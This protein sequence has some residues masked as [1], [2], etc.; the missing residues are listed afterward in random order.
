MV[1]DGFGFVALFNRFSMYIDIIS[2]SVSPSASI[3][4]TANE[5]ASF[6]NICQ[7]I[8][9]FGLFCPDGTNGVRVYVLGYQCIQKRQYCGNGQSCQH[10]GDFKRCNASKPRNTNATAKRKRDNPSTKAQAKWKEHGRTMHDCVCVELPVDILPFGLRSI[11][12]AKPTNA[13]G[14]RRKAHRRSNKGR[15]LSIDKSDDNL[16]IVFANVTK[17]SGHVLEFPL[18]QPDNIILAVET[19]IG[20]SDCERIA[21][22][23]NHN[24]FNVSISPGIATFTHK[25]NPV[26]LICNGSSFKATR[27]RVTTAIVTVAGKQITVVGAYFFHSIGLAEPNLCILRHID[28]CFYSPIGRIIHD[29]GPSRNIF[30]L[31][32]LV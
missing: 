18:A 15:T 27:P 4:C 25:C 3:N 11:E 7:G 16:S 17:L 2:P 12:S 29:T 1:V 13:T 32:E 19:H 30:A 14:R 24:K 31:G 23:A 20:E 5:C 6:R 26:Q 28:I 10:S 22:K 9:A 21:A 8:S